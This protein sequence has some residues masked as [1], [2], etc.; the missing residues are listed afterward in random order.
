MTD[1]TPTSP[2]ANTDISIQPE[3][4]STPKPGKQ[5]SARELRAQRMRQR[6]DNLKS[7][8]WGMWLILPLVFLMGL[9][10]GWLIWGRD[11]SGA[12]AN[13]AVS[14]NQNV[15]RY[16]VPIDGNPS[17]G[18]E[19]APITIVEFSDYQ[20]PYCVRWYK[21]VHKRLLDTYKDKV[22]FVYR[23][24]PLEF[25][26]EA[27]P[28]AEAANCAGEQNAYWPYYDAL[29]G[30]KYP[31]GNQAYSQYAIE[32]GL[33]TDQ[34]QKCLSEHRYASE[35]QADIKFAYSV[36]VTSTPT[37]FIN[38]LAVVGAQPFEVFQQIIDK[39]LAGEISK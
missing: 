22:R 24:F 38:G 37:F 10:S 26:P 7:T 5:L 9:G 18:P 12:N 39:E 31:L 8:D 29:F 28:A 17:L 15:K 21:E 6:R 23:D 36:N 19:D 20:C 13:T 14:V 2:E 30:E 16:T 34:F 25:H 11:A 27:L 35:I 3:Q 4:N 32:L 33:N 1:M